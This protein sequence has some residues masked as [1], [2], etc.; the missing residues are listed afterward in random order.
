MP[1]NT[2]SA[3]RE[4]QYEHIKESVQSRGGSTRTASRIA[5][6]AVNKQR[7]QAGEAAMTHGHAIGKR[8][9]ASPK[10]NAAPAEARTR[11]QLYAEARRHGVRGRSRMNRAELLRAVSRGDSR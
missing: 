3:K 11:E 7:V 9:T 10:G 4:R 1:R 2:W 6:A 5:A 8:A